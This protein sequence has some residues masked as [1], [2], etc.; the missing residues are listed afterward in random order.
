M[1][2]FDKIQMKEYLNAIKTSMDQKMYETESTKRLAKEALEDYKMKTELSVM[3]SQHKAMVERVEKISIAA[4]ELALIREL[5]L[6]N[7]TIAQLWA[8][9][10]VAMRLQVEDYDNRIVNMA[11]SYNN[12]QLSGDPYAK[13]R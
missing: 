6:T 13:Y 2:T 1:S 4:A 8:E 12:N 10:Q 11:R 7:T 5:A 9:L 3:R